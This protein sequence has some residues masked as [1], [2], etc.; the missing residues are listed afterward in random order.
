MS[1]PEIEK[2]YP[3][4]LNSI[5]SIF[6]LFPESYEDF[7][8]VTKKFDSLNPIA[9]KYSLSIN[10]IIAWEIVEKVKIFTL[11][12]DDWVSRKYL[13]S[14][15][16]IIEQCLSKKSWECNYNTLL[17]IV[18]NLIDNSEIKTISDEVD[19]IINGSKK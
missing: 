7:L 4:P 2:N 13:S 14:I 19:S 12:I 6:E 11:D 16:S 1:S 5:S 9:Q 10:N 15:R 18:K 3:S 8:L 17:I